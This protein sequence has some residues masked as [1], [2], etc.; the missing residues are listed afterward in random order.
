MEGA[1]IYKSIF[2]WALIG[3][4]TLIAVVISTSYAM[5][6]LGECARPDMFYPGANLFRFDLTGYDIRYCVLSR[7][8]LR[9]VEFGTFR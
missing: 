7:A 1:K 8:D 4:I 3:S 2:K 9:G 5:A 6:D